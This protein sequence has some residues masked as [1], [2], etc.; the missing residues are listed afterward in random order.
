MKSP[1]SPSLP[2]KHVCP[3]LMYVNE[4][5]VAFPIHRP[6]LRSRSSLVPLVGFSSPRMGYG[7]TL[8][9]MSSLIPPRMAISSCPSSLSFRSLSSASGVG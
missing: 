6:P 9:L 1:E 3:A 8:P 5:A 2:R 4:A 7:S